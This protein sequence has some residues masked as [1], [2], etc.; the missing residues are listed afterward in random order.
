M[1]RDILNMASSTFWA[2]VA[3]LQKTPLAS[4]GLPLNNWQKKNFHLWRLVLKRKSR[5]DDF[6]DIMKDIKSTA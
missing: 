6:Y 1:N 3:I 5:N 4:L 2:I